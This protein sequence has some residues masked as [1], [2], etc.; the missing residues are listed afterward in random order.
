MSRLTSYTAR[1]E[2]NAY[3]EREPL[4]FLTRVRGHKRVANHEKQKT[5]E[6]DKPRDKAARNKSAKR[7]QM[8]PCAHTGEEAVDG[9]HRQEQGLLEQLELEMHVNEPADACI[10][11][12]Y[13]GN[14]SRLSTLRGELRC[15]KPRGVTSDTAAYRTTYQSM[16]TAR[17]LGVM[18]G[19]M[20][21][22]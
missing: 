11:G 4:A 12:G 2:K 8:P 19:C 6:C 21:T 1:R 18:S 7:G 13:G 20:R 10:V 22:R 3:A 15:Q 16:S 14:V 9:V 5:A 17:I